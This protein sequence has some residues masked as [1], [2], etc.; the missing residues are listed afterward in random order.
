MS[1]GHDER[2]WSHRSDYLSF[3]W[4]S[5]KD[6]AD[7]RH[8]SWTC[9][10]TCQ[11]PGR[12]AEPRL[13]EETC[14]L[15]FAPQ[16]HFPYFWCHTC[17]PP[18]ASSSFGF[19]KPPGKA[20]AIIP[21]YSAAHKHRSCPSRWPF[22]TSVAQV[23]FQPEHRYSAIHVTKEIFIVQKHALSMCTRTRYSWNLYFFSIS[24]S[25]I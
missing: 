12:K 1:V 18:C 14:H 4:P 2:I 24:H 19:W 22:I 23:I 20:P 13:P 11:L 10:V 21:S 7:V 17:Q 3:K 25:S 16:E 8:D 15:G 5:P 6:E 9:W